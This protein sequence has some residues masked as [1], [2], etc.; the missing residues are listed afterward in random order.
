[1][2]SKESSQVDFPCLS[3]SEITGPHN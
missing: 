2:A 1:L 3:S